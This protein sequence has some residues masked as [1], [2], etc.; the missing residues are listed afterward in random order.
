MANELV[1]QI[2]RMDLNQRDDF[3]KTLVRKW[4]DM[5]T[6]LSNMIGLEIQIQEMEEAHD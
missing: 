6:S 4:P 3:I 1:E 2:A 5:A